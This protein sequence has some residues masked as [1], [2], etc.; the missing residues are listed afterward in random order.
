MAIARVDIGGGP[1]SNQIDTAE[2]LVT[3]LRKLRYEIYEI[4]QVIQ[5]NKPGRPAKISEE[6]VMEAVRRLR[7]AGKDVTIPAVREYVG[8]VGSN[9]TISELIKVCE[10]RLRVEEAAIRKLT[11][12]Q[13]DLSARLFR[14]AIAEIVGEVEGACQKAVAAAEAREAA[15]VLKAERSAEAAWREV[16]I[17]VDERDRALTAIAELEAAVKRAQEAAAR[18]E[19]RAEQQAHEIDRLCAALER[20]QIAERDAITAVAELRAQLAAM[21]QRPHETA[22]RTEGTE[23]RAS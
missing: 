21:T 1:T 4:Q 3:K 12:A 5:M 15:N 6:M 20:A 9:S 16:D 2:C 17:R 19:G 11:P 7:S 10:E 8:E 18:A 14:Q 13:S 23:E 22:G